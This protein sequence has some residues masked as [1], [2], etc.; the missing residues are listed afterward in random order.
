MWSCQRANGSP[1]SPAKMTPTTKLLGAT[2]TP[3]NGVLLREDRARPWSNLDERTCLTPMIAVQYRGHMR[4][5]P[6]AMADGFC[7][8]RNEYV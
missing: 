1:T 4:L 6:A 2:N 3:S 5:G 7:A 8:L